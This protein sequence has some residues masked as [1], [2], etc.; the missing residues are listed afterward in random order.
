MDPTKQLPSFR[1]QITSVREQDA[2]RLT[3]S[4]HGAAGQKDFLTVRPRRFR[5]NDNEDPGIEVPG[6][7]RAGRKFP[8]SIT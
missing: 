8:G 6:V 3:R 4:P 1:H 5:V 7:F 2:G